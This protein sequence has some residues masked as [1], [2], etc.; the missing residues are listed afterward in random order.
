MAEQKS[1]LALLGGNKTVDIDPGNMFVWPIITDEDRQAAIEVLNAGNMS[2]MDIS[3]K[4]EDE[5]KQWIGS[6]YAL[7]CP[8]GTS[9]LQEA[10]FAVGLGV[11]DE[12]IA[13]S[14]TYW[15]SV[16]QIYSL[17]ATVNFAEVDPETLCIDPADIEKRITDRTKAIMVVHY[18]SSPCDMDPIMEIAKKHN[19]KVIEDVSHAQGSLYKG[20]QL[21]TIG[22]VGAMSM[23]TA[24]S[25]AIGEAGMLVTDD[26]EIYERSII[27]G[28]YLRQE[29]PDTITN[30]ELKSQVG[31]PLG[32][33]K[34]R[35]NQMT[36]AIGRVQLKYYP[37]RIAE[38]DKAM[39]YF[40]DQLEL[41]PGIKAQRPPKDSGHYK[42]GWYCPAGLYFPEQLG[43][44]SAIRFCQ[45]LQAEGVDDAIAGLNKPLHRHP[46]F[47]TI[48]IYGHGKPTRSANSDRDLAQGEGSL[49]VT[50]AVSKRIVRIPHFKHNR[51]EVIDLYI[52]AYKK[53]I[54]NYQ[55]LLPGDDGNDNEVG[56][57]NLSHTK[58]K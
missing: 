19:L 7:T 27:F 29:D 11:G 48:D 54:N 28:H 32:G 44:L 46:V 39:N 23:M 34:N 24:K 13:P 8:N 1:K 40:W 37:Q 21:G 5:F 15:A 17:G 20:K 51:P 50:E 45:A 52:A 31:L 4:F 18:L 14:M 55:D 16:L 12:M 6:E 47:S 33:Y 22:H 42:G 3:K 30:P 58:K 35:L 43:G 49:P 53:V 57:W 38:I 26:R 56:G 25:F 9:A 2:G 10:M 41:L 36:S